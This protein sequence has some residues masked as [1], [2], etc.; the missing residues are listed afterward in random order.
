V[1]L[2]RNETSYRQRGITAA[3]SVEK[4]WLTN[5]PWATQVIFDEG[6]EFLGELVAL[7]SN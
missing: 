1:K 6:K 4:T 2:A 3:S 7:A 5:Y